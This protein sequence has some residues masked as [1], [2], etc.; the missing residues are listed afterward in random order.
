METIGAIEITN[1]LTELLDRTAHGETF[2]I[3]QDGRLVGRLTPPIPSPDRKA[4]LTAIES[5]K[6]LRGRLGD[7]KA[8]EIRA[9]AHEGHKY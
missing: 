2:D 9:M 1:R 5:M 3:M 6:A 7:M 4:A 8:T